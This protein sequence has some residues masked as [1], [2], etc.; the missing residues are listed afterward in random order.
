MYQPAF[1]DQLRANLSVSALVGRTIALTKAGREQK[2]LCPFHVEQTPSFTIVDDKGFFHCFGCGAHGSIFDWIQRTENIDFP[3]AVARAA[4]IAGLPLPDVPPPAPKGARVEWCSITP[5][6]ADAPPATFRHPKHGQPVA[7]WAYLDAQGRLLG[8]VAR[9]NL[10]GGGKEFCPRTWCS[11][12]GSKPSWRWKA[13]AP[14]RPLYGL[15][16]LAARPGGANVLIVEGEGKAEAARR[17]VGGQFVVIS[18][19]GGSKAVDKADL[20]TLVGR[21]VGIWPDHDA[22][23]FQAAQDIAKA[24]D[25]IATKVL[26]IRPPADAPRTWDLADAEREGWDGARVLAHLLANLCEPAALVWTPAGTEPEPPP[27]PIGADDRPTE[28]PRPTLLNGAPFAPLG[29]NHGQFY[30][31]SRAARQVIALS[32]S[33]MTAAHLLSL[34]PLTYW[35]SEFPNF[36]KSGLRAA[37]NMLIQTCYARKV[38]SRD[39]VRGR[40][41]SWDRDRAVLHLGDRLIV[42]G[43]SVALDAFESDFLYEAGE[44]LAA[45]LGYPL[46]NAEAN[47]LVEL[48]QMLPFRR[49]YMSLVLAGW[50]VVAPLCGGMPWRPHLWLTGPSQSGKSWIIDRIIRRILGS[51]ALPFQS[52]TTEAS[53]RQELGID[54]RPVL[55]DEAE[56]DAKRDR[57]RMR[58][59]LELARAA[60]TEGGAPIG[61]GGRDGRALHYQPRASFCYSSINSPLSAA[62]DESRTLVLEILPP[63]ARGADEE[64][65]TARAAHF[66]TLHAAAAALVTPDFSGR[67][68]ARSLSM[69]ATI[70]ANAST[71]A[72]ALAEYL[73][74][75]RAGDTLGAALAGTHALYHQRALTSAE[76]REWISRHGWTGEAGAGL[77]PDPDHER[78]LWRLMQATIRVE[79]GREVHNRTV[80][81]L[82]AI[83]TEC[84]G[85]DAVDVDQA[86]SHLARV[87][88]RV[89]DQFLWVWNRS[90]FVADV[91]RDTAW[92]EAWKAALLNIAGVRHVGVSKMR[93]GPVSGRGLGIPIDAVLPGAAAD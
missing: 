84:Q 60:S 89:E 52:S 69:V 65:R 9:F 24:L 77:Q 71:L 47:R 83:V 45:N 5:V 14:P 68:L 43:E 92:A 90:Q 13:W 70:R 61:K 27:P 2:A 79:A 23:G 63:L 22:P 30:V 73:G 48:C 56:P 10:P 41:L 8:H 20:T 55:F 28:A 31:W 80:A 72:D 78:A 82:V 42:G 93:W 91:F 1:I 87:G 54:A 44:T 4:E 6:P 50:L 88:L 35:E 21:K 33:T 15:D 7:T 57:D 75:R 25:G 37:C 34:A 66:R 17:L 64:Q 39:R 26:C 76:A 46:N 18:W 67:L 86:R 40:G 81:E 62:A 59:V 58:L 53:I 19:P 3:T 74:S 36:D 49:P 16:L 12:P 38:F 51:M 29:Y 85:A 11:A 32:P